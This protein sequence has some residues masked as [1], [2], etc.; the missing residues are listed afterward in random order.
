[1]FK[2]EAAELFDISHYSLTVAIL[3]TD[4]NS[5]K[6]SIYLSIYLFFLSI[7]SVSNVILLLGICVRYMVEIVS[8]Q[9]IDAC[10]IMIQKNLQILID[11]AANKIDI[12]CHINGIEKI[13]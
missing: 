1:M 7:L 9:T 13:S 3:S 12:S 5:C 8:M 6:C 2:P 4:V 11:N 10:Q